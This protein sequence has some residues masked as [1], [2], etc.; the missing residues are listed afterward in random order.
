MHTPTSICIS[1]QESDLYLWKLSVLFCFFFCQSGCY[2][3]S[4]M[5]HQAWSHVFHN[6]SLIHVR[7]LQKAFAEK[8]LV[9]L[10]LKLSR[11]HSK[12]VQIL[13]KFAQDRNK[14]C[15]CFIWTVNHMALDQVWEI[16]LQEVC[17]HSVLGVG[18]RSDFVCVSKSRSE[19]CEKLV[20]KSVSSAKLC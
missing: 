10:G 3:V 20:Y 14:A 8:Q 1:S 11:R 5:S 19:F 13:I 18:R 15:T 6:F 12:D 9:W 17:N 4:K 2:W 7:C 16:R